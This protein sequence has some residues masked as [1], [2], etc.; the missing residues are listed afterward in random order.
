MRKKRRHTCS[1]IAST[2]I[3]SITSGIICTPHLPRRGSGPCWSWAC[4]RQR[5]R[6]W[7]SR[8]VGCVPLRDAWPLTLSPSRWPGCCEVLQTA[9]EC[10]SIARCAGTSVNW[11]SYYCVCVFFVTST[12][13]WGSGTVGE[14]RWSQ[15]AELSVCICGPNIK[16]IL[17]NPAFVAPARKTRSDP[18]TLQSMS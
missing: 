18:R 10:S 16:L 7:Y 4:L 11:K 9:Q 13:E 3:V 12:V 15:V 8:R 2:L 1:T 6:Y 5:S 14:Q 17:G